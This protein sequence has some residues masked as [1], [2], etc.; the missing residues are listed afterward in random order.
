MRPVIP[1]VFLA[2]AL[3]A[4]MAPTTRAAEPG[5]LWQVETT[6]EMTGMKMPARSHQICT[7]VE[8]EGPEALAGGDSECTMSNVEKSAGRFSYDVTCPQGSG[9]GEM[10]YRGKDSYTS[11]MTMQAEGQTMTMTT[12]GKRIGDCDASQLKKQVA[13]V[14]AHAQAQASAGMAQVCESAVS[15]MLPSQLQTYECDPKYRKSLCDRF[16]TKAGFAEVAP[17]ERTG[18]PML[19]SGTLPEIAKYCGTDAEKLRGRFCGE[20]AKSE[21]LE[22]LGPNCPAQ[23]QAIA[24]RECAGRSFSS[25]P[26]P[27]YGEFCSNYARASMQGGRDAAPTTPAG[28]PAGTAVQEG[29]KKLKGLLGF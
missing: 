29:A 23:A 1:T 24:A 9:S 16:A 14:Q 8:S 17:R 25:P 15:T 3:A 20:A 10:I 12:Q 4:L 27:R 18:Q 2:T 13:A 5:N 6:M 26:A 28:D 19:D 11:R 21:D 7:P 22:F